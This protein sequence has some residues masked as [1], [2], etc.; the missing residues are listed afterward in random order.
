MREHLTA[1]SN[2]QKYNAPTTAADAEGV[3][4]ILALEVAKHGYVLF[5]QPKVIM[6]NDTNGGH[7]SFAIGNPT[8]GKIL[9]IEHKRQGGSGN[10]QERAMRWLAP[11]IESKLDGPIFF[12][13]SGQMVHTPKYIDEI[14]TY[15]DADGY[16]DRYLLW[17]DED[18]YEEV[19]NFWNQIKGVLR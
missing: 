14:N 16:R 19:I 2:W 18:S 5:K 6:F 8:N 11:G 13:F 10:A 7:P 4:N 12:I 1:R 17:S 9:Y 3:T 15:F